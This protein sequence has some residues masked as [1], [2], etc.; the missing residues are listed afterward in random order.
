[1][2]GVCER[3]SLGGCVCDERETVVACVCGEELCALVVRERLCACVP[4][5]RCL[6]VKRERERERERNC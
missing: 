1:M 4:C 6:C 2:S 5:V 3:E